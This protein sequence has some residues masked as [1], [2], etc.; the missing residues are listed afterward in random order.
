MPASSSPRQPQPTET[1][2]E[3][4]APPFVG[5][6]VQVPGKD[7]PATREL[8]LA[9]HENSRYWIDFADFS[10]YRLEP[11]DLYYVGGFGVMGWV[12]SDAYVHSHRRPFL[13]QAAAGILTHMN[14]DH[15][16]SHDP[17]RPRSRRSKPLKPP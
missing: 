16:D 17:P 11:L 5:T 14:A 1:S 6:V 9:R 12:A 15:T 2:S 10:F 3:P 7:L 13:A 8:Y 4:P